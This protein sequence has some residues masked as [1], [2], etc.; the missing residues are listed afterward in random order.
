MHRQWVHLNVNFHTARKQYEFLRKHL[1]LV[2]PH[3]E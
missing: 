1:N 3:S 2:K